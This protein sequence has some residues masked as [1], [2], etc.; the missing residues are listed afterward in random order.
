M[1]SPESER[2]LP[3]RPQPFR[4]VVFAGAAVVLFGAALASTVSVYVGL[5]VACF[6]AALI[7]FPIGRTTCS[8]C[9][10]SGYIRTAAFPMIVEPQHRPPLQRPE[11]L[12]VRCRNCRARLAVRSHWLFWTR[13]REF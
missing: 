2:A 12:A 1:S 8:R 6:G 9:G 7:A 5:P 10:E 4:P 3:E 13:L 11:S